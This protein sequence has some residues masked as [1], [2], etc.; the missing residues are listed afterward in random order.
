M[1]KKSNIAS[2]RVSEVADK[3]AGGRGFIVRA[4]V[5]GQTVTLRPRTGLGISTYGSRDSALRQ[6]RKFA[7]R[8]NIRNYEYAN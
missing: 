3:L 1:S 5:K 6:F 2:V 8:E 7:E 4:T